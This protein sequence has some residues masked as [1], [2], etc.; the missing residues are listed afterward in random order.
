MELFY[1]FLESFRHFDPTF[2]S[3]LSYGVAILVNGAPSRV[4]L[5][6]TPSQLYY[7]F[8]RSSLLKLYVQ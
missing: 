7:L 3:A 5:F 8:Y 1:F 2:H 4:W 6:T